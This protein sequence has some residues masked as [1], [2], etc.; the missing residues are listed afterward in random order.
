MGFLASLP[1]IGKLIERVFGVIDEVVEDKDKANQLKATIQLQAMN[2]AETE[3]KE[4]T[5]VILEEARGNW[6][7]RTW[8]PILMMVVIAIIANNYIIY[9]YASAFLGGEMTVMLDLPDTLW[10]L[11]YIGVGGY[12]VG[13]SAEKVVTNLKQGG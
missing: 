5:K 13:R 3:L 8:R 12:V 6:L 11:L 10:K 2:F 9:P 1:I 4:A 7:Q